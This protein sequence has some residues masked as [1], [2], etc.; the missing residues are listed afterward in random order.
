MLRTRRI[1]SLR[2]NAHWPHFARGRSLPTPALYV[3]ICLRPINGSKCLFWLLI[4]CINYS[5][6][7]FIFSS[8]VICYCES[9]WWRSFC[10]IG[11]LLISTLTHWTFSRILSTCYFYCAMLSG[12][13][14]DTGGGCPER[15]FLRGHFCYK[16][17]F[18]WLSGQKCRPSKSGMKVPVS[19]RQCIRASKH[20]HMMPQKRHGLIQ[21]SIYR[22]VA[23]KLASCWSA[24]DLESIIG[25]WARGLGD[26]SPPRLGQKRDFSG[27]ANFFGQKTA[28]KNEEKIFFWYLVYEKTKLILSSEIKC[29]KSWIFTNNYCVGWVR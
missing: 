26:C 19:R 15:H 5:L 12:A 23:K 22:G 21:Y 8:A 9:L 3:V 2:K 7:H 11:F 18:F 14:A 6:L 29:P 25:V 10:A 28:A 20:I 27:K 24:T 1:Y 17:K 13:V 16:P 4:M